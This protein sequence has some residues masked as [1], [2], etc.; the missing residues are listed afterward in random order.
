MPAAIRTRVLRRFALR[1]GAPA[2]ALAAA[3]IDALDALVMAWHGQGHVALPGAI[4]VGREAGRLRIAHGN[5]VPTFSHE[6][7]ASSSSVP[8][9]ATELSADRD[10]E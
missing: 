7:A 10:V 5:D 4:L 6:N 3:H 1:L 2:G 8:E 9:M